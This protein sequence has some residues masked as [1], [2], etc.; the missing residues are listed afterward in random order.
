VCCRPWTWWCNDATALA[1]YATMMMMMITWTGRQTH[2]H[3]TDYSTRATRRLSNNTAAK[4]VGIDMER[5]YVTINL[6]NRWNRDTCANVRY[7]RTR[8]HRL[9]AIFQGYPEIAGRPLIQPI[10]HSLLAASNRK[11]LFP[12]S[13]CCSKKESLGNRCVL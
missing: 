12:G 10:N 8:P 11:K 7:D 5:N 1:G 13:F 2:A 6:R 3:L 4:T 9:T